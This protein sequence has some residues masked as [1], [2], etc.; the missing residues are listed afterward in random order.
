MKLMAAKTESYNGKESVIVPDD[1]GNNNASGVG[2][3]VTSPMNND[4]VLV[5]QE[6]VK[7]ADLQDGKTRVPLVAEYYRYGDSVK[8]AGW[9]QIRSLFCSLTDTEP[10]GSPDG[11]CCSADTGASPPCHRYCGKV[12]QRRTQQIMVIHRQPWRFIF[13]HR[14]IFDRQNKREQ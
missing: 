10:S 9:K 8:P 14:V 7:I 13:F 1:E 6:F 5:N 11:C 12:I 2:F 4:A 3:V